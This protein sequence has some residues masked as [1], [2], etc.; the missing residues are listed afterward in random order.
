MTIAQLEM[1]GILPLALT[2]DQIEFWNKLRPINITA[3]TDTYKRT[4]GESGDTFNL[5]ASYTLAA[6]KPLK[7][8]GA[9]GRLIVAGLEAMLY[10]WFG[11]KITEKEVRKAEGRFRYASE[12]TKFPTHIWDKVLENDGFLPIDIYGLPGGQTLLV[13]NQDGSKTELH[14]PIMSIEGP[15]ALVSHLEPHMT[16]MYAPIIAAT[17]ARL[18][19]EA[20]G[21]KFAEFGYRSARNDLDHITMMLAMKV[22]GNFYYTSNDEAVYLF[23]ETFTSIGTVGHEY[24]MSY[25]KK[26]MTLEDAQEKAFRDF[27]NH[28]QKSALLPDIIDTINSGLPLILKL[29]KEYEGSGKVI[30]PRFD[31]GDIKEQVIAWKKMTLE[32]GIEHSPMVV[33]DGFTPKKS[34]EIKEWYASHGYD[35]NE[36]IVGAGGYFQEGNTRD[37]ISLA[38]K[39]T[40]TSHDGVDEPSIKFSDTPGKFSLPGPIRVYERGSTLI[41]ARKGETVDGTPLYKHLIKNGRINYFESLDEQSA[42]AEATWNKYDRIE[43]SPQIK[44]II[45]ERTRERDAIRARYRR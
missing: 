21:E 18:M 13:K 12:I 30:M 39:R 38:Y 42:R 45:E 22:G 5:P 36:I 20:A 10:P 16:T 7:E 43:Y 15:G 8:E 19:R 11:T 6:R 29:I 31:S 35:P 37:A 9:D 1:E 3:A 4:M 34:R 44:T 17:K 14:V 40:S 23:P 28:N 26:G 27:I 2:E 25:Q 41:V 32:A 33:E 24:I